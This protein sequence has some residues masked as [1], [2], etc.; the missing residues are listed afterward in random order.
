MTTTSTNKIKLPVAAEELEFFAEEEP[1][2]I[3]PSFQLRHSA[4]GMLSCVG[5][6]YGPFRPNMPVEVP[7]WLALQLH[8]RGKCRIIPPQFLDIPRLQALITAEQSDLDSFQPVP[9]YFMEV[10]CLL[11]ESAKDAFGDSFFQVRDLLQQFVN[12]RRHK[13]EDG[14][15]MVAQASTIRLANLSAY[16]ANLI[17]LN[18][19]G[20]L[21]MFLKFSKVELMLENRAAAMTQP[22]PG[23]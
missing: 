7:I 14:L 23:F 8:K 9:F 18:L 15:R 3:I 21:N 6:D 12:I 10:C 1:I 19:Q 20:S 11:F 5:G 2:T 16:E 13:I 4:N 22:T 17:R